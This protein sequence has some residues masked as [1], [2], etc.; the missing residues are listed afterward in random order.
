[1][2]APVDERREHAI[3]AHRRAQQRAADPAGFLFGGTDGRAP[4][5]FGVDLSGPEPAYLPTVLEVQFGRWPADSDRLLEAEDLAARPAMVEYADDED[6]RALKAVHTGALTAF[7]EIAEL[8]IAVRDLRDDDL[9]ADGRLRIAGRGAKER[10]DKVRG[11]AERELARVDATAAEIEQ[12]IEQATRTADPVALATFDAIRNHAK[13]LPDAARE[14]FVRQAIER[15]DWETLQALVTGPAYLSAISERDR[16]RAARAIQEHRVP[17]EVRR[18]QALRIGKARALQA[19]TTLERKTG[20]IL[21]F[22]RYAALLE[23][24]AK[25]SQQYG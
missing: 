20:Q 22:K 24:E 4:E 7:R 13:G 1:M 21:D 16:Q 15:K 8:A 3:A 11:M 19:V 23:R 10:L 18:L 9:N 2:N 6:L 14:T 17:A 12:K 5:G 25:R